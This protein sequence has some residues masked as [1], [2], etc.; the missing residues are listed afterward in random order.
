MVICSDSS[1]V[2]MS[3]QSFTSHSRQDLLYEVLR[4]HNGVRRMGVWVKLMWV[5]EC[6][7]SG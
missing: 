6:R 7:Q 5:P 4:G 1:A 2:L 3:V